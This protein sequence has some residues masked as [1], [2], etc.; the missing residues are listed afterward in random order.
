LRKL[1]AVQDDALVAEF[2]RQAETFNT[3]AVATGADMLDALVE[4]AAPGPTER[5]LDAACGP[6]IVCRRLAG[7]VGAVHGVDLTTAMIEVARREATAAGLSNVTFAVGD[8]T[9]LG[10]PDASFDGA[11][12]RFAIHHVPVPSRLVGELARLV[13]P[14]GRVVLAD[15]LADDDGDAGAWAQEI[16]RLRDPSHWCSLPLHRL[17][18]LAEHA[19]LQFEQERI[20]P[21]RIDFEDWLERGSTGPGARPL[22]ERALAER[23]GGSEH[24]RVA[25][26]GGRRVLELVLWLSSWRR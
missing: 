17:R 1:G 18:G 10:L 21:L 9:A 22:I 8:A 19:Q 24:F 14:G 6:G 5:W 12:S 20:V 13:R 2:T 25:E 7:H 4:L 16:E 3:S 11:I 26:S 15:H 23:P